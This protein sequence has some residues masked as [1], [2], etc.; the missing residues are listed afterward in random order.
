LI[1]F[2]GSLQYL[3][4]NFE[5]EVMAYLAW[6]ILRM[7]QDTLYPEY[8]ERTFLGVGLLS[9][10]AKSKVTTDAVII[11][12]M[13]WLV[14]EERRTSIRGEDF[15]GHWLLRTTYLTSAAQKW[16][17]LGRELAS[18][19]GAGPRGDAVRKSGN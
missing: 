13:Q 4:V 11:E 6:L 16:I 15:A 9:L 8:S 5:S 2:L 7:V 3:D 19:K 12:L 1:Q 10:A 17:A 18:F 14:G